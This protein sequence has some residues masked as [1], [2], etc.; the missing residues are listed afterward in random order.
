MFLMLFWPQILPGKWSSH[1]SWDLVTCQFIQ[2][3]LKGVTHQFDQHWSTSNT[4][5]QR[6]DRRLQPSFKSEIFASCHRVGLTLHYFIGVDVNVARP[7]LHAGINLSTFISRPARLGL[8]AWSRHSDGRMLE[9]KTL[10]LLCC[11]K[12]QRKTRRGNVCCCLFV[13]TLRES[14]LS[15]NW[16]DVIRATLRTRPAVQGWLSVCV[17]LGRG[18]HIHG[19]IH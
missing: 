2:K 3:L 11:M 8:G 9:E 5:V 18:V 16:S 4:S 10:Q 19:A 12:L 6:P 14:K 17:W 15:G 7:E 13:F 1:S